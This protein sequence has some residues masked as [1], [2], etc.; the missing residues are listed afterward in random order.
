MPLFEV[1]TQSPRFD[2]CGMESLA[3]NIGSRDSPA[4]TD[5]PGLVR[6]YRAT[7]VAA[8]RCR[9]KRPNGYEMRLRAPGG[10]WRQCP[11]CRVDTRTPPWPTS[12]T[13]A[14]SAPPRAHSPHLGNSAA[15]LSWHRRRLRRGRPAARSRWRERCWHR[16]GRRSRK[17]RAIAVSRRNDRPGSRPSG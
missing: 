6:R 14:R 11:T 13:P 2:R 8:R 7:V 16:R 5:C 9:K 12:S 3:L 15:K 4:A 1:L 17:Q 10:D